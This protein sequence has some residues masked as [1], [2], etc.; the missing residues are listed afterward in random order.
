MEC[1]CSTERKSVHVGE[2]VLE[3]RLLSGQ[4]SMGTLVMEGWLHP[5]DSDMVGRKRPV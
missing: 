3:R 2:F 1:V 5:I 4:I